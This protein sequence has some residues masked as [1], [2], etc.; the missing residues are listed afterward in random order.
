MQNTS[1]GSSS[2]E[3]NVNWQDVKSICI[4]LHIVWLASGTPAIS[5]EKDAPYTATTDSAW[6][7]KNK[8]WCRPKPS[9]ESPAKP[10]LRTA[11]ESP[12]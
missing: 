5:Q 7:A 4:G 3:Q 2:G 11:W 1:Q 9:P 8:S 6:V 10:S 12:F